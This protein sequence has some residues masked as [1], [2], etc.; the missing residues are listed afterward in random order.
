VRHPGSGVLPWKLCSFVVF[1]Q[2]PQRPQPDCR[3]FAPVRVGRRHR[4]LGSA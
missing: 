4:P 2:S 3:G 1:L